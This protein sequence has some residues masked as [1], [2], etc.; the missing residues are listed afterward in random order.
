MQKILTGVTPHE[1]KALRGCPIAAGHGPGH[2][3]LEGPV[4]VDRPPA[5]TG[6]APAAL[7]SEHLLWAGEHSHSELPRE[8]GKE[9]AH[10]REAGGKIPDILTL[11]AT[12]AESLRA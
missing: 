11:D 2:S 12:V 1:A 4:S 7:A 10:E 6:G 3:K 8:L 9:S 5:A